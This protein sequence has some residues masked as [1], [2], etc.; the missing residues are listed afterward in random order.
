MNL[1]TV[2]IKVQSHNPKAR[3]PVSKAYAVLADSP[4]HAIERVTGMNPAM[5]VVSADAMHC[6]NG[7]ARVR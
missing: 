6:G 2:T 4:E 1:Y 3:K 5:I 7:I